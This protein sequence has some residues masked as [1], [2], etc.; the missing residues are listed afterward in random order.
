MSRHVVPASSERKTCRCPFPPTVTNMSPQNDNVL[1]AQSR[2]VLLTHSVWGGG[3]RTTTND[4]S[5]TGPPCGPEKGKE[6][7]D[8]PEGGSRRAGNN[9]ATCETTAAKLKHR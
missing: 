8:H 5:R 7:T 4:A 9:R 2:N 1:F 3:R 6:E